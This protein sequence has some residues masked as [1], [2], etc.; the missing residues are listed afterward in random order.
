MPE[1]IFNN[2]NNSDFDDEEVS[3]LTDEQ[4]QSLRDLRLPSASYLEPEPQPVPHWSAQMLTLG[5]FGRYAGSWGLS[6]ASLAFLATEKHDIKLFGKNSD[7]VGSIF[8]ATFALTVASWMAK[9]MRQNLTAD[10]TA[11]HTKKTRMIAKLNQLQT[12]L[13][14]LQGENYR[15]LRQ[16]SDQLTELKKLSS[17]DCQDYQKEFNN[18]T[19]KSS[20]RSDSTHG[21]VID[22]LPIHSYSTVRLAKNIG[23]TGLPFFSSIFAFTT[24]CRLM[25]DYGIDI[26]ASDN[27][28]FGK[29]LAGTMAVAL[30]VVIGFG[31]IQYCQNKHQQKLQNELN[32]L[33]VQLKSLQHKYGMENENADGLQTFERSLATKINAKKLEQMQQSLAEAKAEVLALQQENLQLITQANKTSP[34]K[35]SAHTLR[36]K[37]HP[38]LLFFT[39]KSTETTDISSSNQSNVDRKILA[40]V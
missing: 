35:S 36:E 2:F 17:A 38:G 30:A 3:L 20:N 25:D 19:N 10:N 28:L 23:T 31:Y 15:L 22:D 27:S 6:A 21:T 4:N 18:L 8:A 24:F 34:A 32:D 29:T 26:F 16:I 13:S 39:S 7:M 37:N 33:R 40:F 9:E 12:Q 5:K 1:N 14:N 11:I